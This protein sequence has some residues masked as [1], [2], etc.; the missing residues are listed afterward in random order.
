M[1]FAFYNLYAGNGLR[2]YLRAMG[3]RFG[4]ALKVMVTSGWVILGYVNHRL[5]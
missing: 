5:C 4:R 3:N 1:E 2:L